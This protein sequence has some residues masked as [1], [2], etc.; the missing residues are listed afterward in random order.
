MTL[1]KVHKY[2]YRGCDVSIHGLQLH[3]GLWKGDAV[4]T[5][6]LQS[7]ITEDHR[8]HITVGASSEEMAFNK[9]VRQCNQW[10]D[11]YLD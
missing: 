3:E 2:S 9:V 6:G 11:E 8:I 4:I 10:V 7:N 1:K 5:T